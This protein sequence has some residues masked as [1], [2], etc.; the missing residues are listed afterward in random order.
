MAVPPIKGVTIPCVSA[1]FEGQVTL[2]TSPAS[3]ERD[4]QTIILLIT[5]LLNNAGSLGISVEEMIYGGIFVVEPQKYPHIFPWLRQ[6]PE[7]HNAGM[8]LVSRKCG[9]VCH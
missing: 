9:F 2:G 7:S 5:A 4:Y 1:D 6:F 3:N 8:I